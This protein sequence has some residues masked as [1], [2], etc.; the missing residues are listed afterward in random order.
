MNILASIIRSRKELKLTERERE[1]VEDGMLW[2]LTCLGNVA[3]FPVRLWV[4]ERQ[5]LLGPSQDL[6]SDGSNSVVE[7]IWKALGLKES[8]GQ[9]DASTLQ[10]AVL[11]IG[12]RII[13]LAEQR[14]PVW[15]VGTAKAPHMLALLLGLGTAFNTE[16]PD[17]LRAL[18]APQ[19]LSG[20]EMGYAMALIAEYSGTEPKA[21]LRNTNAEVREGY[22]GGKA[23]LNRDIDLRQDFQ[24]LT[25]EYDRAAG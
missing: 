3:P 17:P 19:L 25:S 18:D 20:P 9:S 7:Q 12:A 8:I 23:M 11:Y 2:G 13:T 6:R 16:P 21:V 4:A 14:P 1:C 15:W 5:R 22:L 10:G 24:I